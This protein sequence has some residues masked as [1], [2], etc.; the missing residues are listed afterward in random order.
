MLD[1]AIAHT[2]NSGNETQS[3]LDHLLATAAISGQFGTK[4][5]MG[6][7]TYLLGLL[8]DLGKASTAFQ[9]YIRASSGTENPDHAGED[10]YKGKK[11]DHSTAGAQWL[12]ID[13]PT[14]DTSALLNQL[15][16][17]ALASHHSR[18]SLL[19]YIDPDGASPFINRMSKPY[20]ESNFTEVVTSLDDNEKAIL[21]THLNDS[22]RQIEFDETLKRLREPGDTYSNWYFKTGLLNKLLFSCLLDADRIDTADYTLQD[23][24]QLRLRGQYTNWETLIER[25]EGYLKAKQEAASHTDK[26]ISKL[27]NQVSEASLQAAKNNPG[28]FTLAV[29]TGGGKT[30]SSL[31]FALHHAECH[32]LER[33]FYIIPYTSIID[34]NAN[35]MRQAL[36][37]GVEGASDID[38][39]VLEDHS[40]LNP[41]FETFQH[42]L[43]SENWDAPVIL[44]T[45]VQF[46]EA[47]FG[48]GS[49]NT[50]RMHQL[51]K[52][53]LIF[54]EVQI[55]PKKCV[56]LFNLAVRFLNRVGG[57]TSVLC[58]AT[59]PQFDQIQPETRALKVPA[60]NQIITFEEELYRKMKRVQVHDA[61]RPSKWS[62][63]N[64]IDLAGSNLENGKSVLI[65]VNTRKTAR[66]L[67]ELANNRGFEDCYHLSTYMCP[68]HRMDVL[69]QV[70]SHLKKNEAVLCISTQLIEAGVDIDFD[71]VIRLQAGLDSITQAAGRCNREGRLNMGDLWV[72]NSESESLDRL[73]EIAEGYKATDWVLDLVKTSPE[74]FENDPIGLQA[75]KKYYQA[76]MNRKDLLFEYPI[77]SNSSLQR[78]DTLFNL[79]SENTYAYNRYNTNLS[80]LSSNL[81]LRQSF[82]TAS[83]LFSVIDGSTSGVITSYGKGEEIITKLNGLKEAR[84]SRYYLKQAQRFS[85]NVFN[86]LFLELVQRGVIQQISDFGIYFLNSQFYDGKTGLST[87]QLPNLDLLM[88]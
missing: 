66:E 13:K 47:L 54:D 14:N 69:K 6:T 29:P 21:D 20:E 34:Q 78:E 59:Q 51:A 28:I 87:T 52:S 60:E 15:L 49:N 68:Q 31:R 56:H 8:H 19:D 16:A 23:N 26:T 76:V 84:F 88:L 80:S 77:S 5:G 73:K 12:F 40:N 82:S 62:N 61:R 83:E 53:V 17:N 46:L 81:F 63:E 38:Q 72:V 33:I 10:T 32:G 64:I 55:L 48:S 24:N 35:V 25:F 18:R 2:R 22:K 74:L 43:L 58:T 7:N 50:R 75:L 4:F 1:L 70:Q 37:F 44:T 65:I 67:Y 39:I 42:S 86:S 30:L 45:Q 27:R 71:V 57:S 9:S 85:V 11:I 36:S 41:D 3:L 79:L